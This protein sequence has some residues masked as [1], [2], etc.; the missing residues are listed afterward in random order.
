MIG[1]T[2]NF[3][4]AAEFG[5]ACGD[6]NGF[7]DRMRGTERGYTLA[8]RLFSAKSGGSFDDSSRR[9]VR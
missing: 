6:D 1:R 4:D 2:T 9:L 5:L 7:V 3:D 8:E